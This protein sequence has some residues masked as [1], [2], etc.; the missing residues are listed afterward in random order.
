MKEKFGG[1]LSM[2]GGQGNNEDFQKKIF[3]ALDGMKTK[4]VEINK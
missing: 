4:I 1:M 3:E 2:L